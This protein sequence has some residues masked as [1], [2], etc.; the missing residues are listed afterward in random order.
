MAFLRALIDRSWWPTVLSPLRL[1]F[2]LPVDADTRR[3]IVTIYELGSPLQLGSVG[4]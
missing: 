2:G 4:P 1:R 3:A